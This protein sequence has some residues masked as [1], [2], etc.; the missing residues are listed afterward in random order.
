MERMHA[1]FTKLLVR[2]LVEAHSVPLCSLQKCN[3]INKRLTHNVCQTRVMV[4]IL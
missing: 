3:Q 1:L 4:C 2:D